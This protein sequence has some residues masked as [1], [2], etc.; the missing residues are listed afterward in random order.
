MAFLPFF[1]VMLCGSLM[2]LFALHFTQNACDVL[3]P[4]GRLLRNRLKDNQPETLLIR[5]H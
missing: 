4:C 2:S 1:M 5:L 3:F